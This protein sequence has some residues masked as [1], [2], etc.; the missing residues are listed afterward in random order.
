MSTVGSPQP[1]PGEVRSAAPG[2]V[3]PRRTIN[4]P[5]AGM[6]F[7]GL[8]AAPLAYAAVLVIWY[9][10]AAYACYPGREMLARP[11]WPGFPGALAMIGSIA[12][13]LCL[14]GCVIS[15]R[16]WQDT[17]EEQPGS[18]H[19]LL[20]VGEGR[21]RFLAMAGILVAASSPSG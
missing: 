7:F 11:L 21:S 18:S 4:M 5:A 16:S 2:P 10:V 15:W 13:V 17:R 8:L 9:A 20:E 19:A 1:R 14:A 6:L 12:F 3:T